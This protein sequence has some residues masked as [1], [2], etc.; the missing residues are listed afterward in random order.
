MKH[1]LIALDYDPTAQK[2]AEQ[3]YQF[4]KNGDTLFTLMHVIGEPSQYAGSGYDAIMGF[5]GYYNEAILEVSYVKQLIQSSHEYLDKTKLHLGDENINT[6]VKEGDLADTI[7][8]TAK[9]INA[10]IIVMGSHSKRWLENIVMGSITEK[11]LRHVYKPL[12][13]IPT[14][15]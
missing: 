9:E 1:I 5:T 8:D 12:F 14:K 4:F 2:V 3:G 11:V 10:D 7:I 6:L 15:K 13:I